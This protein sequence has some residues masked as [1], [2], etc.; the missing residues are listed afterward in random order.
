[1]NSTFLFFFVFRRW[2]SCELTLYRWRLINIKD[3]I[4]AVYYRYKFNK[5]GLSRRKCNRDQFWLKVDLIVI[6]QHYFLYDL[7]RSWQIMFIAWYIK[8]DRTLYSWIQTKIWK[9]LARNTHICKQSI[10]SLKHKS[11][12]MDQKKIIPCYFRNGLNI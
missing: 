1:M 5:G 7:Q 4:K 6:M 3:Q 9:V 12:I 8:C 10:T 11:I 2:A